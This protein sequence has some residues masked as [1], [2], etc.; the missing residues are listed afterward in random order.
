MEEK[1]TIIIDLDNS[2]YAHAFTSEQQIHQEDLDKAMD[3]IRNQVNRLDLNEGA[4]VYLSRI[5]R[6]IGVFGDRGSG[7]TSFMISL[8]NRCKNEMKKVE[9]LRMIDPTLVEHK[10]PI[11]LCVIAM[12]QQKVETVLQQQECRGK[13]EA[14][15]QRRE[16][17]KLM[18]R[19]S[20]GI[21]AIDKVGKDYDNSMWQD[22]AYVM[23][24]GL[25]KVKDANA[26]EENI[27]AM[28][29][30]A[31]QILCKDAFLLAF[32]DIDVDVEQ[33]W[34]VLESLRRY[35]SDTH[36][37]SIVSG[38]IKLYG[39]LVRYELGRNLKMPPGSA[40]DLMENELESQYMLKLL[41]PSN[42]INLLSLA[43]L[44][45]NGNNTVKVLANGTEHELVT[46]YRELLKDFGIVDV[47]SQNTFVSFL[48][49]MSLRSQIHFM[50]DASAE[51]R[52][53]PPL[54]VFTS[55]LYASG[56]DMAAL[57][58]NVQMMNISVLDY[59]NSKANLPDC[60][61]LM[62]TLQDKDVNSNFTALSFMECWHLQ[63]NPYLAFDYLLRIGYVRNLALP[64][65][66]KDMV[67]N[68]CKYSGWN[69][70][71]S[72]KNNIGLSMAYVAGKELGSMKEHISLYAM[73]KKAKKETLNALDKVLKE[74]DNHFTR[75]MAMFPFVRLSHNKDNESRSYY[76][77]IVLLAVIG[78]LLK[79][80]D[81]EEMK[82]RINDLKLFRSY[83]MPQE[84]DYF[85]ED[86]GI[87]GDDYGVETRQ[88]EI[89]EL[90]EKMCVWK[91]EYKECHLP[92]YALGRMMT[93]LY[94]SL[95]KVAVDNVGQ[96]MNVMVANVLNSCLIE[97][98]RIRIPAADQGI[99]NNSNL[100]TDT[101][102]FK[103]N[104]GKNDIV[105][106]LPFTKWM[107]ACPMLN[108]FLD[109]ETYG[110]VQTFVSDAFKIDR[111]T[112]PVYEL[113]CKINSKVVDV[114]DERP[115]FSGEKT[116]GW[117]R[118]L[119]VLRDHGFI[120]EVIQENIIDEEDIDKAINFIKITGLF[121]TVYK[122]SVESFKKSYQQ[123]VAAVVAVPPH[124][125]DDNPEDSNE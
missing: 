6:T 39:A 52:I 119:K 18:E 36:I 45:Q 109:E 77:V 79:C 114:E 22:E 44:L 26:F 24:T 59:L 83:Q 102:Y 25:A 10:K 9:V 121:S 71:M 21:I 43:H 99:L 54:D 15:V 31:L 3:I 85:G 124:H 100:R 97:E 34:N 32:D 111:G 63:N 46:L 33:G 108:C 101:R 64:L 69:Q 104:L 19:I 125:H 122:S 115:S 80:T 38:N 78:E 67:L 113:L 92:P 55:R 7:K 123:Q 116:V 94:T 75:L 5:Y 88:D 105:N 61:L 84:E 103:D 60:Y 27:R 74:E 17:D 50:K 11:V 110:K 89:V 120:D 41:N 13:G 28:I 107:M 98:T 86:D 56:I 117:R 96:M 53:T 1:R 49:S 66:K 8:L 35:L 47:P 57:G 73:E 48:V 91:S 58:A 42:R 76:S 40:H 16:W 95:S 20:R 82:G 37:I 14:Y 68:L 23:R 93:R 30:A 29:D 106:K 4:D 2:L 90:A 118:T 72:L 70:M 112:Y 87:D 81:K 65:E 12:I 51:K 62:P